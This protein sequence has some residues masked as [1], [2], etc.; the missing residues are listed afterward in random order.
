[1]G[2]VWQT[3][4]RT[5]QQPLNKDKTSFRSFCSGA[6]FNR[7]LLCCT[8]LCR[9][10]KQCLQSNHIKIIYVHLY[11]TVQLP[12]TAGDGP[13]VD[14]Q[15]HNQIKDWS[16]FSLT[17]IIISYY[18]FLITSTLVYDHITAFPSASAV[19]CLLQ[20]NQM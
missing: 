20:H 5:V 6:L 11:I 12:K 7:Q 8:E 10:Y 14:P 18:L 3:R 16:F 1:M 9:S 15:A 2:G 17:T 19:L 4:N 13:V